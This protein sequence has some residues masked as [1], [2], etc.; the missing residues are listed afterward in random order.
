MK[1]ILDKFES[2]LSHAGASGFLVADTLTYADLIAYN[3]FF[4]VGEALKRDLLAGYPLLTKHS[5]TVTAL[6]R[7]S[8]YLAK[9][10]VT[11]R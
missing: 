3:T 1:N 4:G 5:R 7:I 10:P 9:R 11:E 8:E 6:P 2:Y